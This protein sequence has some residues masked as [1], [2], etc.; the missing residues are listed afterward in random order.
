MFKFFA[1]STI[2]SLVTVLVQFSYSIIIARIVTPNDFGIAAIPLLIASIG[3]TVV[4]SGVGGAL[5]REHRVTKIHYSTVL[6][7]SIV[8]GTILTTILC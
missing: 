6:R 7:F 8:T 3:R 5:V 2:G 1:W 4:E